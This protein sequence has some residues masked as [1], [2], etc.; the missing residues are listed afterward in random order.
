MR[1]AR[2]IEKNV[3]RSVCKTREARSRREGTNW[4]TY[5]HFPHR[6]LPNPHLAEQGICR[7][8]RFEQ[9]KERVVRRRNNASLLSPLEC[10]WGRPSY[11]LSYLEFPRQMILTPSPYPHAAN[12]Q[13]RGKLQPFYLPSH[14]E[15]L[16][17]P[18]R[19]K[20]SRPGVLKLPKSSSARAP[21]A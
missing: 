15:R 3:S 12:C 21:G 17:D 2:R 18:P 7:L 19:Y 8:V 1:C 11:K 14:F 5:E 6:G 9:G 4:Y 20:V 10:R 16:L 13:C